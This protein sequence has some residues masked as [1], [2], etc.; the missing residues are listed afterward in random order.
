[1]EIHTYLG[2]FRYRLFL[3]Y[4]PPF[5]FSSK[6]ES[7]VLCLTGLELN[8]AGYPSWP[9]SPNKLLV[10]LSSSEV[11]SARCYHTQLPACVVARF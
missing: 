9:V 6:E 3:G 4:C 8:H 5:F 7:D 2:D 10:C 1:M 11:L